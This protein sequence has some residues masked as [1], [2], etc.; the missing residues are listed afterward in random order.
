MIRVGSLHKTPSPFSFPSLTQSGFLYSPN[1]F[2]LPSRLSKKASFTAVP[3]FFPCYNLISTRTA[4]PNLFSPPRCC[5]SDLALF[6]FLFFLFL[7]GNKER[8][9][10]RTENIYKKGKGLTELD[11]KTSSP[12]LNPFT[13]VLHLFTLTYCCPLLVLL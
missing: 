13:I 3:F 6:F 10:N 11:P 7:R 5:P 12:L 8:Y 9:I 2:L 4:H 1:P